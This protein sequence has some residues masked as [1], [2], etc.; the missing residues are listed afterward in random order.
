M[1]RE[2]GGIVSLG[3]EVR[4]LWNENGK[5]AAG[6]SARGGPSTGLT[7]VYYSFSKLACID[8]IERASTFSATV[9]S[10]ISCMA[11]VCSRAIESDER[12]WHRKPGILSS[13]LRVSSCDTSSKS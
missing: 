5:D 7:C 8:C 13:Y 3:A 10:S 11:A 9:S 4:V 1:F 6:R 12:E 2:I